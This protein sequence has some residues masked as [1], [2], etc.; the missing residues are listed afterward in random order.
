[1]CVLAASIKIF[2]ERPVKFN[3]RTEIC[4][5]TLNF[6]QCFQTKFE[7]I[8]TKHKDEISAGQNQKEYSS[9]NL[10]VLKFFK[11]I[12][13]CTTQLVVEVVPALD[14]NHKKLILTSGNIIMETGIE[15]FK[16]I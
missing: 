6:I 14:D 13:L 1:M 16:G 12:N 15:T 5:S 10:S 2:V 4:D 11:N 7:N 9:S 3:L 8:R